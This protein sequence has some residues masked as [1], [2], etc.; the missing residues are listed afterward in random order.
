MLRGKDFSNQNILLALTCRPHP[1]WKYTHPP[2]A[3]Q[4]CSLNSQTHRHSIFQQFASDY[5]GI[6]CIF[7]NVNANHWALFNPSFLFL[8][9]VFKYDGINLRKINTSCLLPTKMQ[10]ISNVTKLSVFLKE[11]QWSSEEK[12][13]RYNINKLAFLLLWES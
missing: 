5:E 4:G 2:Q 1:V 12:L 6:I 7:W 11:N 10:L 3:N 9:S 8:L 13:V